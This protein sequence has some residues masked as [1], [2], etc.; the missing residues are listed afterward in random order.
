MRTVLLINLLFYL[1]T[2]SIAQN[3]NYAVDPTW[4]VPSKFAQ[5]ANPVKSSAEALHRG[6]ELYAAQCSLCHGSDGQGLNNAANFHLAAVQAQS[7]GAL[8]WKLTNGN[9]DKGMP[10]FK[11]LSE[12]DRWSLVTYLRAFRPKKQ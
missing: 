5:M 7:D 9:P 2:V 6:A 11:G 4:K 12:K 8:F 3:N 1:T 10:A